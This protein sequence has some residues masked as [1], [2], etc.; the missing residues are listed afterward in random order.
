MKLLCFSPLVALLVAAPLAAQTTRTVTVDRP[1]YDATRT[2]TRDPTSGMVKRDSQAT[3]NSDGAVATRDFTRTRTEGSLSASGSSTNFA[4][5]SRSFDYSR[6]RTEGGAT[7]TGS[8]TRRNGN[9]LTY[10][11]NQ[12][13]GDGNYASQRSVTGA[14]GQTLYNRNATASRSDTGVTRS[15]NTT[16]NPS[17]H[18]RSSVRSHRRRR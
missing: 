9:T 4:G 2:V 10:Q 5:Q 14:N 8:Y 17:F 1:N 6:D 18:P 3:R 12:S 16:R 13:Y 15:V 11:A 7:A